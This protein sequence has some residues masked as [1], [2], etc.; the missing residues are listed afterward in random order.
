MKK[1][2]TTAA[3]LIC[4]IANS[5]C[6]KGDCDNGIGTKQ[7]KIK[8][9]VVPFSATPYVRPEKYTKPAEADSPKNKQAENISQYLKGILLV[10]KML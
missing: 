10:E 9:T 1:L 7:Y 4:F 6:K 5:Q 2:I 8:G 3:I